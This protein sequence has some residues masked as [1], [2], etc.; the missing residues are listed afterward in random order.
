LG[1]E[2]SL[3]ALTM[4]VVGIFGVLSWDSAFPDRRDVLVLAPL[5][6]RARTLF[7]AK[8]AALA[9]ALSLTVV[10]LNAL[11]GLTW[12]MNCV[13]KDSGFGGVI[14]SLAAYWITVF[15][16][17]GFIFC[18]VLGVHGLAAQLPRRRYLRFSALLQVSAFCLLLSVYFLQPSLATPRA[19]AAPE[20]RHLLAW[21]PSYWFFGLFQ[22]LNGSVPPG[23]HAQIAWLSQRALAGVAIAGLGAGTSF[24]LSYFRTLRKIVE[25]PDIMPGAH[26]IHWLPRFGNSF[27]T[28][29]VHFSIRTLLRSRQHRVIL[30]FYLGVGLA[31]VILFAQTPV[32]TQ[33]P[34]KGSASAVLLLSSFLMLCC[35]VAGTRVIF[36]MPLQLKGNWIFRVMPLPGSRKSLNAIRRS[37]LVLSVVPVWTVTAVA[38][39]WSW[40]W[41]LAAGHLI[42]LGFLG[43]ILAD[44]CLSGFQKI[45]FT[46]SYLPGRSPAH[47]GFLTVWGTL[48][49]AWSAIGFER[50]ALEAPVGYALM[51]AILCIAAGFARWWTVTRANLPEAAL[52]FEEAETPVIFALDLHRDGRM[53][54]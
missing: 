22:V 10:A 7:L 44:L 32:A 19:L 6:V 4:L 20:S 2:H 12:P 43:M 15:A 47:K 29:I 9:T 30:A 21:L 31:I 18:C 3:I 34:L 28:A 1:L 41:Q 36:A 23:L 14:R 27:T 26:S 53:S 17:G 11:S 8:V 54:A 51:I 50:R 40:S 13:V 42:V 35:S 48:F 25:E 45:P 49:A 33:G 16:A 5:P 38:L 46:C 37:L 24:L 52:L 39:F